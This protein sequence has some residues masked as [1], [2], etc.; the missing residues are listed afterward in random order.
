MQPHLTFMKPFHRLLL[1][2]SLAFLL[3]SI[4]ALAGE[5]STKA[6]PL[7][8]PPPEYPAAMRQDNI[9]GVVVVKID[10]NE[11]GKVSEATVV[12]SSQAKLDHLALK[13]VR[14]WV[15]KPATKDGAIIA[16]SLTIPIQLNI[17]G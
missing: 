7:R 15:F 4:D 14:K 9:T 6:V 2:C 17:D 8:T 16:S 1:S 11:Q 13:A 5:A 3:G 12:K 10:I